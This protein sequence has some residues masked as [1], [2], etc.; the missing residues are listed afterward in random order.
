MNINPGFV[1]WKHIT[2][3]FLTACFS[4]RLLCPALFPYASGSV[5]LLFF[6]LSVRLN[7]KEGATAAGSECERLRIAIELVAVQDSEV[8]PLSWGNLCLSLAHPTDVSP[9]L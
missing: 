4:Y 1:T 7:S 9:P 8:T 6:M 2:Q 3:P 5:I